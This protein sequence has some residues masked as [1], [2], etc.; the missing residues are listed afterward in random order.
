MELLDLFVTNVK[1]NGRR[2]IKIYGQP[3]VE[4]GRVVA[5]YLQAVSGQLEQDDP[6]APGQVVVGR[7]V[8]ARVGDT[9]YRA[10]VTEAINSR[11]VRLDLLDHGRV[12]DVR[13]DNIRQGL[14]FIIL[15]NKVK[16]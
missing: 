12:V 9:W 11:K 10:R 15:L 13:L 14:I 4:T 3:D 7:A 8:I 6:P 5:R 2:L 1:K 16:K